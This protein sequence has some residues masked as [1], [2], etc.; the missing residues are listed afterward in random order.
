LHRMT[1]GAVGALLLSNSASATTGLEWKWEEGTTHRYYVS[2]QVLLPHAMKFQKINNLEAR[3]VE[4]T[5]TAAMT[6]GVFD[7]VGKAGWELACTF[8]DMQLVAAPV[9]TDTGRL[10]EILDEM[11]GLYTG[12]TMHLTMMK[13]GKF[14]N[15][16]LKGVDDRIR[17]IREIEE[18]MRLVALRAMASLDMDFP[19]RGDD[20][21]RPWT[22][23][24]SPITSL[25]SSEGTYGSAVIQ[26]SVVDNTDGVVAIESVGRG[27]IATGEQKNTYDIV[28]R[29]ASKFDTTRGVLLERQYLTEAGPTASSTVSQ[30]GAGV[31][32]VQAVRLLLVDGK[33]VPA[34]GEN[35]E[36]EAG[37]SRKPAYVPT[38]MNK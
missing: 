34:L 31:E 37:S 29:G 7:T 15:A 26:H 36:V 4:F 8:D 24:V 9:V 27:N 32:Y 28:F 33:D 23:G 22:Q 21:G 10:A 13:H 11:D 5:V 3:V 38:S 17:R 14:K 2:A 30:G 20:G 1:L 18:T 19:K 6:C 12:S 25:V 35:G 16:V